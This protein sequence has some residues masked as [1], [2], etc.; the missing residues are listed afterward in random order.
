[1]IFSTPLST[2]GVSARL[3][4]YQTKETAT[5]QNWLIGGTGGY[6]PS[7]YTTTVPMSITTTET[8][9][10]FWG[11]YYV[12]SVVLGGTLTVPTVRPTD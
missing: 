11:L 7:G 12:S 6:T 5:W 1:M 10:G 8:G 2:T 3:Q 4:A 9:Q